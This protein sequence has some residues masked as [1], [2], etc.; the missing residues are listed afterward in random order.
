[1]ETKR[2]RLRTVWVFGPRAAG[3][4]IIL[5]FA[6]AASLTRACPYSIRDATF[7]SVDEPA[8]FG[9]EPFPRGR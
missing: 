6:M 7:M 5:C 9:L 8:P 4:V 3:L 1:M 2:L